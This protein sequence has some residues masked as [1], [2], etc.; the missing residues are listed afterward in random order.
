M[1]F[2]DEPGQNFVRDAAPA[3]VKKLEESLQ[4]ME[5]ESFLVNTDHAY[6]LDTLGDAY[7]LRGRLDKAAEAYARKRLAGFI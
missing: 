3:T 7:Q 1:P 4:E 2:L 5:G 6:F